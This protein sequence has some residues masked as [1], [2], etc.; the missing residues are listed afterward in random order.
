M[1]N[2]D[3]IRELLKKHGVQ[4]T[5]DELH[6]TITELQY[7]TEVWLNDIERQ[8]FSGKTLDELLINQNI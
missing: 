5:E 8:Q 1:D 7:L 6:T 2:I 4:M 3:E